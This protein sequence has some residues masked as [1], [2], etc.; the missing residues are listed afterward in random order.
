MRGVAKITGP[1]L[2]KV[3]ETNFYEVTEFHK[4]TVVIDPNTVK[5]KLYQYKDGQWLELAGPVKTGKKVT[6]SFPQKW[7]GKKLLVEAYIYDAEAKTPPGI[8][9]SPILGTKKI[10]NTEIL[11]AH[12]D[13]ITTPP[14][15][16][17]SI[18]LKVTTENMLGETLKLS[19]WERDTVSDTGHDPTGNQLLWEGKS[20]QIDNKG[21]STTKVVLSANMLVLA[22][23]SMF[24]GA[25]HEYY[26]LVDGGTVKTISATTI[27]S[28]EK[29]LSKGDYKIAKRDPIPDKITPILD[30]ILVKIKNLPGWDKIIVEGTSKAVVE[31]VTAPKVE[32]IITAYFA[33]EEFTKETT[34]DAGNYDYKFGG[35]KAKNKTGTPEEKA[36]VADAILTKGKINDKLKAEKRYTTKEAIVEAL[37]KVE[38]GIDTTDAKTVAVKTFKLGANFIKINSAPL[39]EEVYVVAKTYLLDGK[40][41]TITIKEKEAVLVAANGDLTVLEAKE[42]G[43]EITALK[44]TVE[45]GIAKVKIKLRPKADETLAT[46]K[47][48]LA[49]GKEDGTHKY[50]VKSPFTVSGDLDK[51]AGNIEKRSNTALAPNHVV[52]KADISK[53]LTEG[54]SYNNTNSFVFPKYKKEKVVESLWL[55]AEC[56]GTKKHEGEYLKKDGE[57]FVIGKKC[58]CE[59]RIRAFMRVIRVGEG[60][61]EY[62]K[63]TKTAR[64]PELGYT[65]WFSG[66]GNNFT[67]SDDHPRTINHNSTKTVYSSAAGA[68]QTMSWKFDELNGYKLEKHNDTYRTVEPRVYSESTDKAK[69]YDAKGFSQV[70]QDRLCIIILKDD[71]K[72][73]N[74]ILKKDIKG[75][76]S[77]SSGTWVSLPGATAGQPT[78]KMQDTLDYYDEFLKEELAGKSNL[79]IKSGFLKEFDIK[80]SCGNESSSAWHHPLDRMELRGWY[81]SGFYP[82][83]S[84]HGAAEVRKAKH[85]DGLDLYAPISTTIYACIDGEIYDDYVS[86]T[87]GNTLGIKGTYKGETYYFFYAH[88]SERSVEKAATVSA[89]DVIGKTGQS[90]NA[91]GQSAKMNHLHFEVRNTSERTGGKLDPLTTIEE[92]NRDVITNPDQNTQT[93]N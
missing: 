45:G 40:E 59:A 86:D 58:E 76:I 80:C 25:E 61:G 90:G 64:D 23:K 14:K 82:G 39:E 69:K 24:D 89:G 51:I 46:W 10:L 49:N 77:K 81:G 85:H 68:Y 50:D 31:D 75:A 93:G 54:A 22:Q 87:Y 26:L 91:S 19:L 20:K 66:A 52:K 13:K 11:D 30:Q 43:A 1:A 6:F 17:Q 67:L 16:G 63:G 38:Y 29:I 72:V 2:P 47:E 12:G 15:Y 35:T 42:N 9:V 3:G 48:K 41:V 88:L 44:A 4:G 70:S 28:T 71:I 56:Q 33:K 53:L 5:W 65:T 32:G 21:I 37:T 36:T 79:H 55:K 62:F 27:V 74:T 78:A 34:D 84:D 57:Y 83:D 7:Y 73:I 18:T 60:T 92:L 8:V